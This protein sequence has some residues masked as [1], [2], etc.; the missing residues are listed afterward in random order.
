MTKKQASTKK[1][2]DISI[3][4]ELPKDH[5]ANRLT[6]DHSSGQIQVLDE[7]GSPIAGLRTQ[8]A[9]HYERPKGKK[10]QSLMQVR[11]N[12]ISV[13]GMEEIEDLDSFFV[14]DTN[15]RVI[16][17]IR[18][19]A[20]F[21]IRLKLLRIDNKYKIEPIDKQAFLY[22]FHNIPEASNPE[23]LAIL[24]VA[25]DVIRHERNLKPASIG[26]VTDSELRSHRDISERAVPIYG[27][28]YLPKCFRLLYAS[29]DTG[30]EILNQLLR[31]CDKTS[32]NYLDQL[33]KEG[34]NQTR[35]NVALEEPSVRFRCK[36]FTDVTIEHGLLNEL[37]LN[38]DSKITVNFE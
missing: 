14:I 23:M 25:N 17:G 37:S 31:V 22:E 5:H 30:Q 26:F 3:E 2:I 29:S 21:F 28:A 18:I 32:T 6:F 36:S 27:R 38:T 33:E 1:P 20:T 35:L 7:H 13:S 24:K 10:Y 12:H 4:I 34:L 11:G 8:R 16:S 15:N 19:S 9:V